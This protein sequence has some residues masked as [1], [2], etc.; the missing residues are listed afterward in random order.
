MWRT[1]AFRELDKN[2]DPANIEDLSLERLWY[3][4]GQNNEFEQYSPR[5]GKTLEFQSLPE[6]FCTNSSET[7]KSTMKF[8]MTGTWN[9]MQMVTSPPQV[10]I[11][12]KPRVTSLYNWQFRVG[13][14]NVSHAMDTWSIVGKK[15][16]TNI[17][18]KLMDL[19][20]NFNDP[21]FNLS[22]SCSDFPKIKTELNLWTPGDHDPRNSAMWDSEITVDETIYQTNA[23]VIVQGAMSIE[24]VGFTQPGCLSLSPTGLVTHRLGL[25]CQAAQEYVCEHQSCYTKEGDECVFPFKY[26]GVEYTKCTSEDVYQPW[27]ASHFDATENLILAWGLCLPDCEYTE[28]EVSCLAPPP[29]PRF[30]LRNDSAEV[31]YQNYASSWFNITFLNNTDETLNHTSY[32]IY[33]A[34]RDKLWQ[35]WMTY[36]PAKLTE[37]NLEFIAESKDDHFNDVYQIM[38]NTSTAVYTCPRGW[39]FDNSNNISHTANCLNWKWTADFNVSAPCVRKLK[40]YC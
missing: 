16:T 5:S 4:L 21:R 1:R 14:K 22:I 6:G 8:F 40:C 24:Y 34:S 15:L 18:T 33:R 2:K 38:G 30:G 7:P 37:T 10:E 31:A 13:A 39:V 11:V 32:K 12:I 20:K 25:E 23:K 26:K 17:T 29:L 36:D 27:C 28:P 19:E 9:P 3:K 35:P